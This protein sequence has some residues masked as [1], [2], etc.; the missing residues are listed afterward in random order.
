MTARAPA[1]RATGKIA[2]AAAGSIAGWRTSHLIQLT[3]RRDSGYGS[4]PLPCGAGF[5][6]IHRVIHLAAVSA[7][8]Y[9]VGAR[10]A[11]R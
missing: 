1:V 7:M 2:V 11:A 5:S 8:S 3:M 4:H 9:C 6:A 10:R